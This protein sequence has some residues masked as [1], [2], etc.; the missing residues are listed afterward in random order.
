M[1]RQISCENN[2]WERSTHDLVLG[3]VRNR[4]FIMNVCAMTMFRKYTYVT[5]I[6]IFCWLQKFLIFI[7]NSEH[8]WKIYPV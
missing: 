7:D 4:S 8:F 1:R 2:I 5:G 3:I 6:L